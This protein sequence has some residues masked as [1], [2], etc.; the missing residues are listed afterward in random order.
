M[1]DEMF[2]QLQKKCQYE[3]DSSDK[4]ILVGH[5]DLH[6]VLKDLVKQEIE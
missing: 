3:K 6:R 2:R 4:G 5:P 1:T